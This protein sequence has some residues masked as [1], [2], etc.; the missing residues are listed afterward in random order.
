MKVGIVCPYDIHRPGG[1]QQHILDTVKE[2][3]KLGHE[4]LIF[5]PGPA[6]EGGLESG[7]IHV[8]RHRSISF[9]R[10]RF[11]I[12]IVT[13][14][15]RKGL[16]EL[17]EKENF[18]LLHFHTV[19]T[20]ILA[21]QIFRRFSGVRIATF[22]DTPPPTFSGK[23]TRLLFRAISWFL[24]PKFDHVLTVSE[25]PMWHLVSGDGKKPEILPPCTDYTRFREPVSPMPEWQDEKLNILFLGRLEQRKGIYQMLEAYGELQEKFTNLRLLVV[26]DG[27]EM[28]GVR[29]YIRLNRLKEVELLG[30]VPAGDTVRLYATCDIYCS[31]SLYGESFGIVLVEAMASGKPVVAAANAGY[32]SVLVDEGARFLSPP[33]N[34]RELA[35]NLA[36]LIDDKAL[37]EKMSI[38]GSGHARK[39]DCVEVVPKLV[40]IYEA[41]LSSR[42]RK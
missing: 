37:R 16:R 14:S 26:G 4:A 31:P 34:A 7:V 15:E 36:D 20:P 19:W 28:E 22:H 5:A 18:D 9:N 39:F 29:E 38:W 17:I 35:S 33:G 10:T 12:S 40:E 24:L 2:L 23:M 32:A 1:V 42:A 3:Q 25:A 41:A 11:E 21:F 6:P 8:G 13:G 30:H 27:Q